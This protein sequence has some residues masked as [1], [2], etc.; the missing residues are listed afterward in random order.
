[1]RKFDKGILSGAGVAALGILVGLVLEGGKL[2]QIVQPTAALIVMGGTAGAVL[3]QFPLPVVRAA[4]AQLRE[5]LAGRTG[6]TA[7]L[8]EDLLRYASKARRRGLVSLDADLEEIEDP[9]CRKCLMLAVDGASASELHDVMEL[10]LQKREEEEEQVSGVWEAA[11]GFA[12]TMGIIG[13]VLGLIQVMQKLDNINEVGKGIAVAFVATLY[14][15]GSANLLFLPL[16]GKLRSS[17][18]KRQQEREMVLEAVLLI[19]EGVSPRMLRERLQVH[20][21]KPA[22]G[23]VAELVAR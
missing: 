4:F 11:G 20:T 3:V 15:V 9:F 16:A 18:R 1:M 21:G 7:Q 2:S 19:V 22:P 8:S 10:D 5:A 12:P 6:A 14:G 17:M 23:P 13:A